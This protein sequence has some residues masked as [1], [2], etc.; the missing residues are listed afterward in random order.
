[1]SAQ[2][3]AERLKKLREDRG[4]LQKYVA[5]KI[6]VKSNTLSGYENGTRS[7]EPKLIKKL[8]KLYGVSTDYLLGHNNQS[9][10]SEETFEA[11]RN[12]PSLE[13]W[14]KDLPNYPE[15]DLQKLRKIWEVLK[16]ET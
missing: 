16:E 3:L 10:T 6:D 7:P 15:V 5:N 14:Y 9:H 13:R 12:D 2:I 8:A 11:F 4:Y 1:M